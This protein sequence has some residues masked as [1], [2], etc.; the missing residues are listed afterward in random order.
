MTEVTASVAAA[1]SPCK[2]T[3]IANDRRMNPNYF[4]AVCKHQKLILNIKY[5][6]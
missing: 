5:L 4:S 6:Q 1:C 3:A 2:C